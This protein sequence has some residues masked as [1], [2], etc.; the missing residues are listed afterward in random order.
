[1]SEII[2]SKCNCKWNTK[3]SRFL[4]TCP[5][6]CSKVKNI[7]S[8]ESE[9][10]HFKEYLK[11]YKRQNR[12]DNISFKI[13]ENMRNRLSQALKINKKNNYT[14][15]YIGC[16]IN[17]LRQHIE[18]QFTNNMNWNNYG[19][20]GWHIDHI[21]PCSAFDF[22]KEENIYK[23]FHYSNL[24][25]LWWYDNLVKSDRIVENK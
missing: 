19:M 24:Q 25:P 22:S 23:C 9:N 16:S 11:K 5:S 12:I 15:I 1:M 17:E 18:K 6:C 14:I 2:C 20:K 8:N 13:I 21:M 4:I 7:Y 3:S 10:L